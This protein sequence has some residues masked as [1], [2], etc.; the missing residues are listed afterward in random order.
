MS[1][2]AAATPEIVESTYEMAAEHIARYVASNGEDG[3]MWRGVPCLLITTIGN[4]SGRSIRQALI[5][6]RTSD[7]ADASYV[8]V[9]SRGG[10]DNHPSWYL[11]LSANPVVTL[12]VGADVFQAKARTSEGEERAGLW[13]RLAAIWPDYNN[14]QAKTDRQIPVV[15][16]DRVNN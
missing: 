3:H 11:N 5:Y 12:Q 16:L 4:K 8:I 1:Q 2:D 6:G 15:V 9:A 14:Y 13:E 7:A 10:S